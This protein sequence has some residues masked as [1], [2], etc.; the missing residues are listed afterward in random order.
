MDLAFRSRT[1][2]STIS[3]TQIIVGVF[4]I[5]F[6]QCVVSARAQTTR[7]DTALRL[8]AEQIIDSNPL[9]ASLGLDVIVKLQKEI[10][11][12]GS[13]K[14]NLCYALDGSG[15]ITLNEYGIQKDLI[16]LVSVIAALDVSANYSAVQYG[17]RNIGISPFGNDISK[18]LSDVDASISARAP[19]T[20]IAAGIASC[21]RFLSGKGDGANAVVVLG[22]GRSNF[23]TDGLMDVVDQATDVELFAVGIGF[24]RNQ[25]ILS[26]ITGGKG[27]KLFDL[28]RYSDVKGI[29]SRLTRRLCALR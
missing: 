22:D 7:D 17:L 12:R 8:R 25:R 4:V 11:D 19:R 5:V 27:W 29:V 28:R 13:C 3:F 16:K 26:Q 18:F 24:P 20:F 14:V 21:A 10:W 15:S 6:S 9:A 23:A 1:M 2:M